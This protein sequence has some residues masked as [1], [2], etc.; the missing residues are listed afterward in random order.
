M[1]SVSVGFS[2][3]SVAIGVLFIALFSHIK[4]FLKDQTT[5]NPVRPY[6]LG[7]SIMFYWTVIVVFSLCYLG[8]T[9]DQ[10]PTLDNS[11]LLL[12]GI[13][14]GTSG[15]ARVIDYVQIGN[16]VKRHQDDGS[17]GFLL[18]I[19]SDQNGLSIHRFQH[20]IFNIVYGAYFVAYTIGD[21]A[22]PIFSDTVL[23][24]LGISSGAYALL[25]IPENPQTPAPPQPAPQAMP[26]PT[27]TNAGMIQP[28]VQPIATVPMQPVAG[29]DTV[30]TPA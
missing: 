3:A 22:M 2:V 12:M 1:H 25:K 30:Q 7:R 17:Q 18:D 11:V 24:L 13:V 14:V 5:A 9:L 8:I 28:S 4:D 15:T 19:I 20:V 16:G 23:G 6:S 21:H 29:T 10:M 26:Q 27:A